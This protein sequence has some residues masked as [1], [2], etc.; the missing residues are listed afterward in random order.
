MKGKVTLIGCPKLDDVD[1]AE[2]LTR[3]IAENDIREFAPKGFDDDFDV[4]YINAV[5]K[6]DRLREE[7]KDLELVIYE[8]GEER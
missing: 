7:A 3:I 8:K 1:Y 6:I 4:R 2:K 5:E